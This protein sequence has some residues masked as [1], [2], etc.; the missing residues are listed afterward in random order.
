M[1][2][3]YDIENEHPLTICIAGK[4]NIAVD[5]LDYLYEKRTKDKY[6][7]CVICNEKRREIVGWQK[8][9]AKYAE[10]RGIKQY[11]LDEIY[12]VPNLLFLSLEFDEIVRPQRFSSARLYNI[13]FS[14]LPAY[15]GMYTSAIPL[16]NGEKMVGVTLHKID[17]GIDTGDIIDQECF[18]VEEEDTS[19]DLYDKYIKNGTKLVLKNISNLIKNKVK[20]YRQPSSN[21]TYYSKDFIDYSNLK[22]N[23]NVTA[24]Q[25]SRQIRAFSFREYQ[26]PRVNDYDIIACEKT[27]TKSKGKPGTILINSKNSLLMAT[28]DYNIILYKDRYAELLEACKDGELAKVID[29]CTCKKH[30][31]VQSERGWTPLIVATYYGNKEIVKWLIAN[32]ANIELTNYNK[33][34]LLMYAKENYIKTKDS[35]L[36]LLFKELGISIYENDSY[37]LNIL[38]YI[39]KDGLTELAEICQK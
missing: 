8:S 24:E 25:V 6:E 36:F 23:L 7:L 33:T 4:N 38:D 12:R 5:V 35:E 17:D 31:N 34:N 22:I 16:L 39:K 3:D 11:T 19:R 20:T 14:F 9:L 28:V 13:H 37:G 29:I 15:K 2:Y 26:M 21:A 27:A 1:S 10:N 32:G 18:E 30:I